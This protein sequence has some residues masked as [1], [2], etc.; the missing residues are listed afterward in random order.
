[1][2]KKIALYFIL[3][4]SIGSLHAQMVPNFVADDINGNAHNL[5]E[6]LDEGKVVIVDVFATWC[7][8]CWVNLQQEELS[9]LY[10]TYGPEGTDQLMILYVEVDTATSDATLY[11]DNPYGDWTKN[12]PYPIFNPNQVDA[13]FNKAFASYGLPTVNVICPST[14]ENIADVFA[15]DLAEIIEIIQECNTIDGVRDIQIVGEDQVSKP[16]CMN[17][18]INFEV[19]N[20][21]TESVE[22]F[23][24][25]ATESGGVIINDFTF[26]GNLTSGESV[27]IDL[28]SFSFPDVLD[29][30]SVNLIIETEDDVAN[31]NRQVVEYS[32]APEVQNELLLSIRSDFWAKEDN[33]RWWIE[34]SANE[35]VT[36]VNYLTSLSEQEFGFFLEN[37]D[38][39]TF[40]IADDFGDGLVLGKVT[41]TDEHGNVL[42]DDSNF[43]FRGEGSFEYLGTSVTS[44]QGLNEDQY[45]LNIHPNVV[46]AELQVQLKF[47]VNLSSVLT[48]YNT[49]G[50][51]FK[52]LIL[53]KSNNLNTFSIDVQELPNGI[54]FLGLENQK[55][56]LT[57][58]FIKQS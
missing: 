47:D 4:F 11:D 49:R 32:H 19:L 46:E 48:I 43:G 58:K 37:S 13:E 16:I 45:Q 23:K 28:G 41:L 21:G 10:K 24:V 55:G 3:V 34:N 51:E 15:S 57:K 18:F 9:Q 53:E 25:I 29:I 44:T 52:S 1:M 33:T 20:T 5:Y 26:E 50:Q 54:Y 22:T 31:N 2:V 38:C 8:A 17:T 14:R 36:P 30:Q 40:V 42:Y 6:Y 39:F 27:Q 35:I 7:S 12:V 56:R